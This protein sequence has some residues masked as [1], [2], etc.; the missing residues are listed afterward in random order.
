MTSDRCECLT[1]I[2]IQSFKIHIGSM[3]K[4]NDIINVRYNLYYINQRGY[5][6][7]ARLTVRTNKINYSIL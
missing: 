7:L 4:G 6:E 5:W 2:E 3:S 1:Y